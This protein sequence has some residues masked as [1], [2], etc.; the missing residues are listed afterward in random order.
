MEPAKLLTMPER[1]EKA[2]IPLLSLN[3]RRAYQAAHK[4]LEIVEYGWPEFVAPGGR[5]SRRIDHI[6]QA[7]MEAWGAER[8]VS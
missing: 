3:E 4:I 2:Y 5:R 8:H 1:S 7:I 6:A